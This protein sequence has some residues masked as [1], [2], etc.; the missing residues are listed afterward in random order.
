MFAEEEADLSAEAKFCSDFIIGY[1][2]FQAKLKEMLVELTLYQSGAYGTVFD[3]PIARFLVSLS[4]GLVHADFD[5]YFRNFAPELGNLLYG[6]EGNLGYWLR[7]AKERG[8]PEPRIITARDDF[9]NH[10][11]S[12]NSREYYEFNE[13]NLVI[14]SWGGHTGFKELPMYET[15]L[16]LVF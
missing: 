11:E 15:L 2:G 12:W 3:N 4:A 14:L 6:P 7:I 9:L 16:D 5:T 1:I 13:N 10:V 8:R